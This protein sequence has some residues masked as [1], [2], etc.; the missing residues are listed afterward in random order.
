MTE[1]EAIKACNTIV[2]VAL[3]GIQRAPL[4]MTKNE[5][6]EAIR[7]A[8]KA[9]AEVQQYRDTTLSPEQVRTLQNHFVDVSLRLGEYMAIGTVEELETASKYLRLV[10]MCGTVGKVIEKCAEYEEIGTPEE[11]RTAIEKQTAKTPDFE[12]DGSYGD[13]D[14]IGYDT[15]ICPSC[16]EHYEIDHG[17]YEYCPCCGQKV[18]WDDWEDT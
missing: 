4:N 7:M 17:R 12:A 16:G 6:A 2:F 13:Y 11:C 5:L 18:S 9:L 14:E 15:W 10:K 3:S 1:S 8:V